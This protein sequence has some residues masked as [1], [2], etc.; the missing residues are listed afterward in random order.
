MVSLV[1]TDLDNDV[2]F[3]RG[4]NNKLN[5]SGGGPSLPNSESD[6]FKGNTWSVIVNACRLSGGTVNGKIVG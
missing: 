5:E 2:V 1:T 6:G 3:I 4:W